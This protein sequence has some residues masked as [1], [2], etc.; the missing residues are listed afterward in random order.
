MFVGATP[1]GG[2]FFVVFRRGVICHALITSFLAG[3]ID[4]AL[5]NMNLPPQ[6]QL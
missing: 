1:C 5:R 3:A 4:W 2:F 6:F